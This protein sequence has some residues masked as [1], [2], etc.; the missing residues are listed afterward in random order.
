MFQ[1][2]DIVLT[3][4]S[5]VG[6]LVQQQGYSID[7]HTKCESRIFIRIYITIPK[8]IGVYHSTS[9]DLQPPGP[10]GHPII[11][12]A[13]KSPIDIHFSRGLCKGEIR[14]SKPNPGLPKHL[15]SKILQG[16]LQVRKRNAL[17][18]IEPLNLVEKTV[19]TGRNGLIA[20]DPSGGNGP[21][22]G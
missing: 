3:E 21:D 5:D 16:L 7:P 10:L 18:D 22:R 20:V 8:N 14:W 6:D 12:F 13:F 15:G 11:G 17:I 9:H 1:E 19:G 2:T 4:H